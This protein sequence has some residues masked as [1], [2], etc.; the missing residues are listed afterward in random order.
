MAGFLFLYLQS[1]GFIKKF[2]FF[3]FFLCVCLDKSVVVETLGY[4][5]FKHVFPS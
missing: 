3:V 2:I 4:Q 5:F 1:L